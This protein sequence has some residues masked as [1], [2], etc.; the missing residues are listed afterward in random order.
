MI[1]DKVNFT[2]FD[3]PTEEMKIKAKTRYK[4]KP[5]EATLIPLENGKVKIKFLNKQKSITPGQSVVFYQGDAVI[6]GGIIVKS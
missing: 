4:A 1:A 5:A 6:G 2:L 3:F